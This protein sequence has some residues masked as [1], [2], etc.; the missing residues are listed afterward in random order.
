VFFFPDVRGIRPIDFK[1]DLAV[2]PIFLV[3]R[4]VFSAFLAVFNV[5]NGL[6]ATFALFH[7]NGF[8]RHSIPF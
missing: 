8:L 4:N 6:L 5:R 1:E 7:G 3:E 2:K